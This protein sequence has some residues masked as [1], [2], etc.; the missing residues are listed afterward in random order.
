M[1]SLSLIVLY[2][3]ARFQFEHCVLRD[4]VMERRVC[5]AYREFTPM[6]LEAGD[7]HEKGQEITTNAKQFWLTDI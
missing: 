2:G 7:S 5:L 6:Y 1:F 3:P 4:D